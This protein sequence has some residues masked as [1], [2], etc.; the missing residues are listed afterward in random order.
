MLDWSYARRFHHQRYAYTSLTSTCSR[1]ANHDIVSKFESFLYP[2]A[3]MCA[4]KATLIRK[5]MGGH[6]LQVVDH[7]RAL[8]HASHHRPH[9]VLTTLETGY[10]RRVGAWVGLGRRLG[11][12]ESTLRQEATNAWKAKTGGL[13]GCSWIRCPLHEVDGGMPGREPL[14]CCRCRS[15]R[16]PS[17]CICCARLTATS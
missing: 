6:W 15:V 17:S 11:L 5:F 13:V 12:D 8:Q 1:L 14:V 2:A 9:S 16:P 10:E 4:D 7:L 3:E